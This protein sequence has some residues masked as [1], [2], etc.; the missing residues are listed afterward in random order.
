[1][2]ELERA[3]KRSY[4]S[5]LRQFTPNLLQ[6]VFGTYA[7]SRK[8]TPLHRCSYLPHWDELSVGFF[9]CSRFTSREVRLELL[10]LSEKIFSK[11][12]FVLKRKCP[13]R[14]CEAKHL[15]GSLKIE[16]TFIRSFLSGG[17]TLSRMKVR[18]D[19]PAPAG[20]CGKQGGRAK[21]NCSE[22]SDCYG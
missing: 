15:T 10:L 7:I 19:P 13:V 6:N 2:R 12:G 18:H 9:F 14:K 8:F 20:K 11:G 22:I 4:A 16:Y 17:E 3:G 1:M 5:R 21:P